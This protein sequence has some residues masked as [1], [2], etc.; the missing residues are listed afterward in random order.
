ML[1]KLDLSR[2]DTMQKISF[3]KVLPDQVGPLREWMA[4]LMERREEVL[5]TFIAETVRSE[6]AWLIES[7]EGPVLVFCVEAESLE[8]AAAAYRTSE[9]TIDIEHQAAM[10]CFVEDL[11]PAELLFELSREK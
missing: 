6:Q 2:G 3:R 1:V 9:L 5:E 7:D 8:D 11:A 4:G 10:R